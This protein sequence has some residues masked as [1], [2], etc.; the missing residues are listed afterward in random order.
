MDSSVADQHFSQPIQS[1]DSPQWVEGCA[2][3]V[4]SLVE[5][6]VQ[7]VHRVLRSSSRGQLSAATTVTGG[8]WVGGTCP[9]ASGQPASPPHLAHPGVPCPDKAVLGTVLLRPQ[10]SVTGNGAVIR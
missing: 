4:A 7:R 10:Q 1:P 2:T 9:S 6:K 8:S 3:E 5:Q